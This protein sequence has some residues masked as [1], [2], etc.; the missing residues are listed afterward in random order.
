[1]EHLDLHIAVSSTLKGEEQQEE[2]KIN[3]AYKNNDES[4]VLCLACGLHCRNRDSK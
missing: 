1:V 2:K 3:F 4:I